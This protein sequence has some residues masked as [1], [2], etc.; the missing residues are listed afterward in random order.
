MLRE[1]DLALDGS[2]CFWWIKFSH[3]PVANF[4]Q[5][6]F[7]FGWSCFTLPRKGGGENVLQKSWSLTWNANMIPQMAICKWIIINK[8]NDRREKAFLKSTIEEISG[9]LIISFFYIP[10]TLHSTGKSLSLV[11]C[12]QSY[13]THLLC[14]FRDT[15]LYWILPSFT[16]LVF[17]LSFQR[18]G[19]TQKSRNS[20]NIN[21][22][23]IN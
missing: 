19:S 23:C 10:P 9:H 5:S 14:W 11:N 15:V 3:I 4:P 13:S 1:T 12:T 6:L 17:I 20:N 16:Y 21:T 18:L 7:L 22:R 8:V 2:L